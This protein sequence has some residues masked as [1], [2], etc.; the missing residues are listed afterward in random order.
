MTHSKR[1]TIHACNQH[2][3][4]CNAH[5]PVKVIAPGDIVTFEEIDTVCGQLCSSLRVAGNSSFSLSAISRSKV[6][7]TEPC[8]SN[9]ARE[10][11]SD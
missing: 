5:P 6:G 11:F 10:I 1:H 3:S 9:S 2:L 4:W 8:L 7:G